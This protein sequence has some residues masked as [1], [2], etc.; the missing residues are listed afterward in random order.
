MPHLILDSTYFDGEKK[1]EFDGLEPLNLAI[2]FNTKVGRLCL[3]KFLQSSQC[4]SKYKSPQ[5]ET[6]T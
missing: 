6:Y 1:K 5:I 3:L 2:L 4:I